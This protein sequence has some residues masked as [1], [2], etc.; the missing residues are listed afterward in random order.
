M[1]CAEQGVEVENVVVDLFSGEH[2]QAPYLA[3]NPNGMVPAL[4]DDGFVLTES[5]TILKYLADKIDSPTF[6]KEARARARV[7]E[8]MDWVNSNLYRELGYHLVY[9]QA[10]PNHAR[11]TDELTQSIV[12]WGRERTLPM[13]ELLDHGWHTLPGGGPYLTGADITIADYLAA[14]LIA[15]GDLIR[16]NWSGYPNVERWLN[17]MKARP[18][19][20]GIHDVIDGFAASM[21]DKE[22][23]TI[24]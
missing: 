10:F 23:T 9:P 13:L 18:S 21:A 2:Q 3:V 5:P 4:D 8:I 19:W 7:S 24:G 16:V 17:T 15:I 20:A 12:D 22:F 14:E 1:F 11:G 6:P